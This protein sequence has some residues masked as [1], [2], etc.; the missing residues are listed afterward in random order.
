MTILLIIA[1]SHS[2]ARA[3]VAV[4]PPITPMAATSALFGS[5]RIFTPPLNW[6]ISLMSGGEGE[7]R[8]HEGLA[9]LPVFKT[10]DPPFC[11]TCAHVIALNPGHLQRGILGLSTGNHRKC[12]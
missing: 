11:A 12:N 6:V 9:T 8:T 2:P 5:P 3:S 4:R 7:I 10:P 1:R